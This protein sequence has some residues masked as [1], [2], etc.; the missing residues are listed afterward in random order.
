MVERVFDQIDVARR[1]YIA[2]MTD[3]SPCQMCGSPVRL[4]NVK[5]PMTL[6][7]TTPQTTQQRK[8]TSSTCDSNRR[9]RMT[10]GDAV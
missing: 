7:E 1:V 8:C 2:R 9:G 4:V 10:L 6:D 5:M 3:T